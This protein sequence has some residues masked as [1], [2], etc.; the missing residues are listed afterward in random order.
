V[1][2]LFVDIVHGY[3]QTKR[4]LGLFANRLKPR[5]IVMDDIALNAG[6]RTLWAELADVHPAA[7]V[8]DL[9]NAARRE[10]GSSCR[11][12]HVSSTRVMRG[13]FPSGPPGVRSP[14]ASP[15]APRRRLPLPWKGCLSRS[16]D[17]WI[18]AELP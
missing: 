13:A 4:A 6:M 8:S 10:S 12:I 1:D 15:T 17:S 16:E 18:R 11:G 5:V 7:D 2:L 14:R 3:H 9:W